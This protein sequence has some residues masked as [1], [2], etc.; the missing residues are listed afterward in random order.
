[1]M[2]LLLCIGI[3]NVSLHAC[4]LDQKKEKKT[5]PWHLGAH[6]HKQFTTVSSFPRARPVH[7][8]WAVRREQVSGGHRTLHCR[9]SDR[10]RGLYPR[11]SAAHHVNKQAHG[12]TSIPLRARTRM[13]VTPFPRGGGRAGESAERRPTEAPPSLHNGLL[14]LV[15]RTPG[16]SKTLHNKSSGRR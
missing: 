3:E 10:W 9:M 1:M 14:P 4:Y 16:S 12:C 11:Q 13:H 6:L 5:N 15:S 2:C 7:K 8:L